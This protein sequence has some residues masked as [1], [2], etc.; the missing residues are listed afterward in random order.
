MQY[1]LRNDIERHRRKQMGR[2]LNKKYF[3]NKNLAADGTFTATDAGLGGQEVASVTVTAG[4]YTVAPTLLFPRPLLE[5]DGAVRATGTPTFK[6]LTATI[7][8][9]TNYGNAQTFDLTVTTAAGSAVLNVT[10]TAG[11]AITT[12]NSITN[13]GV[14]TGISAVT[15]I[16]GG[17]GSG[18]TV[19]ITAYGLLGATITNAGSGYLGQDIVTP[20]PTITAAANTGNV[21]TVSSTRNL[22]PGA[23]LDITGT[24]IGNIV[25]GQYFVLTVLSATTITIANSYA[26][27]IAGTPFVPASTTASG[28]MTATVGQHLVIALSG[29]TG[30]GGAMSAVLS[31][32]PATVST[33]TGN[34]FTGILA[35]AY[36]TTKAIGLTDIVKQT[37]SRRYKVTNSDGTGT[38]YLVDGT[39]AL[40]AGQMTITAVDSAG[41]TYWVTKLTTHRAVLVPNTG[42]QFPLINNLPQTVPWTLG[43]PTLNVNVQIDNG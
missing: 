22:V 23:K 29:G 31:T 33:T 37:G 1:P 30:S 14:F 9:G 7:S 12:V 27:F 4:S 5:G 15:G 17:A 39:N 8:G 35:T 10:S 24:T 19:T 26:N 36:I 2:P 40:T 6:V 11:G 34:A 3:G 18:A 16:S 41:G 21:V 20:R 28:T 43:T 32:A 42:T 38:V 13:A 25:A